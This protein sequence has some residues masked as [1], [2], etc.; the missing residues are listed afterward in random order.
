MWKCITYVHQVLLVAGGDVSNIT[1]TEIL[2]SDSP[3]WVLAN[4][5]PRKVYLNK[6]VSV[7]GVLY[8]TGGVCDCCELYLIFCT[9]W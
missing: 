6:G 1:P 4:P 7:E 9:R 8:M 3:A 2:A 5:L